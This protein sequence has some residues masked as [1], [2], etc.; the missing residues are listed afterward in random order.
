M[1]YKVIKNQKHISRNDK[2]IE[3]A[4][5]VYDNI[6]NLM[7]VLGNLLVKELPDGSMLLYD[8][9]TTDAKIDADITGRYAV[10]IVELV[11]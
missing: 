9:N 11:K 2:L 7:D 1:A 4:E 8:V 6:D 5:G 3:K 10:G